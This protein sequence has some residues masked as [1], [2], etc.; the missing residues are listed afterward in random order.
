M[1]MIGLGLVGGIGSRLFYLQL[2]QGTKN[3]QIAETNRVRTVAKP[4][5]RGNIYDRKGKLLAGNKLSHSIFIWPLATKRENWLKTRRQVAEILNLD[6][7]IIQAKVA[8][9]DD[10]FHQS[11]P[12]RPRPH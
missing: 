5:V 1:T 2:N 7:E 12:H 3:R 6:E 9:D 4:P 11:S 10:E 8:G